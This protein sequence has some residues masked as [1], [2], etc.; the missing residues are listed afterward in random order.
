VRK[1]GV[2]V[3]N[4]ATREFGRTIVAN[5]VMLGLL[6][7]K[8]GV[9]SVAGME[10]AIRGNVPPKTVDMNLEAFRKGLELAAQVQVE[11]PAS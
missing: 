10:A 11:E 9:V 4:L 8:T 3:S 7:D 2:P 1:V 5:L 6:V